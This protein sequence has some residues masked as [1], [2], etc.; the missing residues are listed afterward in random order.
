M[1]SFSKRLQKEAA[2]LAQA[3]ADAHIPVLRPIQGK[4]TEWE[5]VIVGPEDSWYEGYQFKLSISVPSEYPMIPPNIKFVTKIFHPNVHFEVQLYYTS[6]QTN[7][8]VLTLERRNM[9][10]YIEKGVVTCLDSTS[11]V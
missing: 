9:F 2:A 6:A 1:I 5:A 10:G 4:I 3:S 11:S 7:I 8:S